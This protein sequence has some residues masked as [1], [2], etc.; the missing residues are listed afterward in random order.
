MLN[1]IFLFKKINEY[2]KT[3]LIVVF[4][5]SLT[6]FVGP[7]TT[8]LIPK[9]IT[10]SLLNDEPFSKILQLVIISVS[11]NTV[12]IVVKT[13][14][15]EIYVPYNQNKIQCGISV[16]L[17]KKSQKL[18]LKCY[19]DPEFYNKYTRALGQADSGLIS[20][21]DNFSTL[22]DRLFY[23]STVISIVATL[24][25]ILIL[26]GVVCA[27]T[28][29]FFNK[30]SSKY[31][32]ETSVL[33]TKD[34]RR[35][36][37]AKRIHYLPEYAKEIRTSNIGEILIDDYVTAKINQR[38]TIKKRS[39]RILGI[40]LA[41]EGIRIFVL[42]LITMLY[43]IFR[44][45]QGVLDISSFVALFMATMQL[46]FELFNFVNCFNEFYR[47]SLYTDDLIF[48]LN[49]ISDIETD[50]AID[51]DKEYIADSLVFNSVAFSYDGKKDVLNDIN[52][53][54]SK[55]EHIAL[56]GYNGAGKTSLT[57]L[58]LRLYDT[59]SGEVIFNGKNLKQIDTNS[60]RNTFGV[61]YQDYHF[62]AL[63]VAE[64]VLLK[65]IETNEERCRV[66]DALKKSQLYDDIASLP[67]GIDTVLTKEF[68]E[69]GIVLSGGQ[70][71][72]LALARV[73]VQNKKEIFILDE[74]SSAMDPISE[75]QINNC[76]LDFCKDKM[77]I[78]ISH[79]LS[80]CKDMDKIYVIDDGKIVEQGNH[81]ELMKQGGVY[82]KMYSVQSENYK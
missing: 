55:G 36:D 28:L 45:Q 35:A 49:Y 66:I 9:L 22:V 8:V 18:D 59:N 43:L 54:I 34:S 39:G 80:T 5:T 75:S 70:A 15:N 3:Y 57:K 61:V 19:D 21:I 27:F 14:F 60:Y 44:I 81:S 64:N 50:A 13:I 82:S 37:Y 42:Q 31:R 52:I 72:K 77:L 2:S 46:S 6:A 68:D 16:L 40:T 58:L 24:D 48:V 63:T 33:T 20:F 79:R 32:Y 69:D 10:D 56:V 73:F 65:R 23:I 47:L 38:D 62:Y 71:Q 78:L 67:N 1:N 7:F 26:F 51:L 12:R 74:A 41:D 53:N 11:A 76:I 25:P 29:F 30:K 17:M 4:L